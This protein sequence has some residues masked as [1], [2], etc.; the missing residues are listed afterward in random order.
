[1]YYFVTNIPVGK[2]AS[3]TDMQVRMTAPATPVP[4][5]NHGET[6][7]WRV[8]LGHMKAAQQDVTPPTPPSD[9][10]FRLELAY[11][12]GA[13]DARG[14]AVTHMAERDLGIRLESTETRDIFLLDCRLA[15]EELERIAG[16]FV[17]PVVQRAYIGS[18]PARPFHWA[19]QVGYKPGVTD[20]VGSSA[21]VAIG[22]LLGRT[23]AGDESAYSATLYLLRGDISSDE[24]QRVATDLLA[25]PLI[26]SIDVRSFDQ[27]SSL[28]PDTTA[29]SITSRYEP[30]VETFDLNL[31]DEDLAALS[32]RSLWAL[33]PLEMHAIRDHFASPEQQA[34]RVQLGLTS[35]PTDVEME[36]LAQTWSEHCKHKIFNST[37]DY[38]DTESGRRRTINS[39]FDTYIRGATRTAGRDKDWLLSVFKDNAGVVRFTEDTNLVFK[40]ETHNTPS[41]LDPYGGAI[42]GIVGVNR[43]PFGTGRGAD[44]LI[45]VWGY[46]FASPFYK[47]EVP[48][49]LMHP[50]RIRD[51]VHRGVIDGGN[52]SGIPYGRG[53]ELFD[54][55]YLGKPLVYCGTVGI[56]PSQLRDG[57]PSHEKILNPGDV[58]VMVG[59][60]IGADGIHGATFSS[61][62]LHEESPSQAVQIGDPIT[63]KKMTDFLLEALELGLFTSLTDN[64]AGGLSSSVGEM[65]QSTGG[66]ELDLAKAPLKYPGLMPWEI[67]LSEAQERMSVGVPTDNLDD[68]LELAA[69]REV[70]ATPLGTF[71]DSGYFH[72]HYGEKTVAY[73]EMGFLHDGWPKPVLP[74]RWEAPASRPLPEVTATPQEVMEQL[75]QC[76]N[77]ASKEVKSRQYDHEVKG[78]TVVKPFTGV[79]ADVPSE[80]TVFLVDYNRPEGVVL[81]EGINPFYSDLDTRAMAMA[82]VDEAFR[83]LVSAG[84]A[85]DSISALDN[86]CW[87][88]P[89][90]SPSTPDGRYKLAQLIRTCEGMYEACAAYG[91]PLI[92]GKDS[93]KN[94][95][96]RGGVKISIPPTLL[97]SAMGRIEDIR[98][99]LTSEPK[100]VG[101][102]VYAV[103]ETRQELGASEFARW[104]ESDGGDAAVG[105]RP[106]LTLPERNIRRYRKLASAIAGGIPESVKTTSLGG[107]GIA[108]SWMAFGAELGMD[109]D[110]DRLPVEGE[111]DLWGLLFSESTGRFLVTVSPQNADMF[112][113]AMEGEPV[114][115]LGSVTDSA[116]L[117][118]TAGGDRVVDADVM[119]LKALWKSTLADF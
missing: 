67:L 70:E 104:A 32:H 91:V 92:S 45:N 88:D 48:E 77:I 34:V 64:G 84:A 100:A 102:L 8:Y 29:P 41:A 4:A 22:D 109:V 105:G 86:F 83:R 9:R 68:F 76:V 116:R 1:M 118:I 87:P 35:E 72:V 90:E 44:L 97:V 49:G 101:D 78:R 42:T 17:D 99:A 103:G 81:A 93:M 20:N 37:L 13:R 31:S 59:G 106:P 63:Q 79:S 57:A 94:D 7:I 51:G 28:P 54:E 3:H 119:E 24:A 27:W 96:T 50:R 6:I 114:A 71:T 66:A 25:N 85:P 117:V 19:I 75:L 61:Q 95:S 107:L 89:V 62:E 2:E 113:T 73:L 26:Q 58:I 18:A 80:A 10:P 15:G 56:M 55:R 39:L 38:E 98:K 5:L 36:C 111:P 47:G 53:W 43:D 69:R 30:T 108:L 12:P 65:A 40:V 23:L 14:E 115:G 110:L 46:C 21:K 11:L 60:R 82:V 16:A 74:A 112:E 52:Q 33:S